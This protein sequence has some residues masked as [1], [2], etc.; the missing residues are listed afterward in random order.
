MDCFIQTPKILKTKTMSI[1][2]QLLL[3]CGGFT[4]ALLMQAQSISPSTLNTCGGT[5]TV[6]GN[7]YEWS[8]GE[9]A[10]VNTFNA[11]GAIITQGVLQPTANYNVSIKQAQ[12]QQTVIYAYP[13]P[14]HENMLIQAENPAIEKISWFVYDAMGRLVLQSASAMPFSKNYTVNLS[15]LSEGNYSLQVKAFT[16]QDTFQKTFNIQKIK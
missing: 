12:E 14:V 2:K 11:S 16:A 1:K 8:V 15:S 4:Q 3:L 13:N 5:K 10:L 6:A 7:I 9:M